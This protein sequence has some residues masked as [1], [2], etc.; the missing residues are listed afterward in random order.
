MHEYT[1][2]QK[3]SKHILINKFTSVFYYIVNIMLT[4]DLQIL[5]G[6]YIYIYNYIVH[7]YYNYIY[8]YIIYVYFLKLFRSKITLI[9]ISSIFF[10][11]E[12][13]IKNIFDA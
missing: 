7:K 9:F 13:P 12:S 10:P 3:L 1:S 2:L 8:I 4:N 5:K 6:V 11:F